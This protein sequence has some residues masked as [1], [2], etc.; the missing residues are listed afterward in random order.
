[1]VHCSSFL[2]EEVVVEEEAC[3]RRKN[4]PTLLVSQS[5]EFFGGLQKDSSS[6]PHVLQLLSDFSL[7][8][9]VGH[10]NEKDVED[11]RIPHTTILGPIKTT[12]ITDFPI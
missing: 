3:I 9:K 5:L 8:Q 12:P 4:P 10:I 6:S 1:M 7:S 2:E 11:D